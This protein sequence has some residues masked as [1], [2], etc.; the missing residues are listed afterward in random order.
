[1]P[2]TPNNYNALEVFFLDPNMA[3]YTL[4][5]R[6]P[7]INAIFPKCLETFPPPWRVVWG[8][9]ECYSGNPMHESGRKVLICSYSFLELQRHR[10]CDSAFWVTAA[11][12]RSKQVHKVIGGHSAIMRVLLRCQF[13]SSQDGLAGPG[14]VLPGMDVVF[15]GGFH[16]LICDGDGWRQVLEASGAAV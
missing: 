4:L 6:N 7:A 16:G 3:L 5:S 12:V 15:R 13:M 8:A 14:F 9:D 1:M 11:I 10:L 2:R